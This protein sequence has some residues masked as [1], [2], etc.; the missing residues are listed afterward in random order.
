MSSNLSIKLKDIYAG[1]QKLN[2]QKN[3]FV[4]MDLRD[5]DTSDLYYKIMC[6]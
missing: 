5:V 6:R 3:K 2:K 1:L 4:K